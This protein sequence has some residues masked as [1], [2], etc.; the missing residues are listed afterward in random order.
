[1]F[2]DKNYTGNIKVHTGDNLTPD[3]DIL[4]TI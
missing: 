3:D 4:I 1:M 2:I